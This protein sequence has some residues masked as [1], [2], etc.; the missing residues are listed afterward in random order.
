[1]T[2]ADAQATLSRAKAKLDIALMLLRRRTWSHQLTSKPTFIQLCYDSSPVKKDLFL[3]QEIS[4]E[5]L[6]TIF[7]FTNIHK[8]RI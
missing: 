6:V 7:G 1:M 5:Q 3:I 8:L 2:L 4:I